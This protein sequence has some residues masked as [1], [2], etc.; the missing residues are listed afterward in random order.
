MF[1]FPHDDDLTRQTPTPLDQWARSEAKSGTMVRD[2]LERSGAVKPQITSWRRQV[3][4]SAGTLSL[5]LGIGLVAA[6]V[7]SSALVRLAREADDLHGS[8]I[9]DEGLPSETTLRLAGPFHP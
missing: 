7:G 1:G 5:L 3:F 4:L 9:S 6:L 2:V 8:A